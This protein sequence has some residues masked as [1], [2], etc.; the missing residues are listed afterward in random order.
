MNS[1]PQTPPLPDFDPFEDAGEVP[2]PCVNVCRV[3]QHSG[4]CEGCFRTLDEIVHWSRSD[5]SAKRAVW[6][7]I[8]QR[9]SL[10]KQGAAS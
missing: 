4:L 10:A 9:Q 1:S 7:D 8:L 6:V 5:E 2:S 3:N